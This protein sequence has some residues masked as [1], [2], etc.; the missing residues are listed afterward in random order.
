MNSCQNFKIG[1][2]VGVYTGKLKWQDC[3]IVSFSYENG[4]ANA[5]V[6]RLSDGKKKEFSCN[7]LHKIYKEGQKKTVTPI[8]GMAG[9]AYSKTE[10]FFYPV[11]VLEV[12]PD[13]IELRVKRTDINGK[14]FVIKRNIFKSFEEGKLLKNEL[15]KIGQ[16]AANQERQRQEAAAEKERQRQEAA[17]EQE[18]QRQEE[19]AAE[20]ERQR[21]EEAAAEQERQR[22]E[23]EAAE[24]ERK[25]K[26][27]A[28]QAGPRCPSRNKNPIYCN[29]RKDYL[30]QSLIFHPD[31]NT[32]CQIEATEKFK[33]L[34][35]LCSGFLGGKKRMNKKSKKNKKSRKNKNSRKR[36]QSKKH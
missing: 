14:P 36:K 30:K 29:D 8:P 17:A 15:K 12:S 28:Q 1:D 2:F 26:A 32:D 4:E 20:Q 35:N 7:K 27:E 10:N 18:R 3:V 24:Q 19:E 25:R 16:P 22:Q 9:F 23:E 33:Q 34:G 21:Q 5:T 13:S 31:K 6:L 11:Q